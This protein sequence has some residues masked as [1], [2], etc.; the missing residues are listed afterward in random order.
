[1]RNRLFTLILITISLFAKAQSPKDKET[2]YATMDRQM[3]D[4]N[5]G[6]IDSFMNGYWESDSLMFVGKAG[7]TYGYKATHEG[8][9]K[10]YPDRATMGT[11]KFTYLNLTFPGKDVAFLVGKFHLTRPEK[12]DL[13]GHYTLL[14]KK[15]NG[16][17]VVICDHT[18]G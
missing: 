6:D 2:I 10:R 7:I 1:M 5:R 4:W 16:K 17:W 13:E 11:L 12:G 8:Y 9:L 18:S 3:A 14:W 15:I